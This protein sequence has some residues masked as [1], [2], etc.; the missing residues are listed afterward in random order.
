[1]FI[2]IMIMKLIIKLIVF[3]LISYI[4]SAKKTWKVLNK[5]KLLIYSMLIILIKSLLLL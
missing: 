2:L 3:L 4:L 1:M 5:I